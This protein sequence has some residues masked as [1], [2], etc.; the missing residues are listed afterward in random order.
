MRHSRSVGAM[1][2]V[3]AKTVRKWVKEFCQDGKFVIRDRH[4]EKRQ[5]DSFI[6]DEDFAERCRE[7]IDRRVYR[8]KKGEPRFRVE[9]F[10]R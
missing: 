7:E 10:K 9:A 5:A 4:Y 1:V 6:D 2:G 3:T 8:R